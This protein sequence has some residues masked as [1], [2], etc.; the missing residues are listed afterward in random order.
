MSQL[1]VIV[2]VI[3]FSDYFTL[4]FLMLLADFLRLSKQMSALQLENNHT[5]FYPNH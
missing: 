2:S 1:Y 3:S 4:N 5:Y